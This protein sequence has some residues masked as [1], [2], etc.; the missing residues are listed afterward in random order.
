[1]NALELMTQGH[2]RVTALFNQVD[3]TQ[4]RKRQKDLFT[5]I[6][7]EIEAFTNVEETLVYPTLGRYEGLQEIVREAYEEHRQAKI[8]MREIERLIEGNQH[9]DHKL[10]MLGDNLEHH[11]EEEENVMFTGAKRIFNSEQLELLGE[12]LEIAK[13]RFQTVFQKRSTAAG[14]RA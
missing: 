11:F 1:M 2:R 12:D 14:K 4:D 6:K 10:K 3:A 5:E 7:D 13:E 8:L 9:F